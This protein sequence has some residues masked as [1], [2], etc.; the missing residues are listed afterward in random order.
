MH[1]LGPA[2]VLPSMLV[3][4]WLLPSPCILSALWQR[5]CI[6]HCNR[7]CPNGKKKDNIQNKVIKQQKIDFMIKD[8]LEKNIL[9]VFPNKELP[10]DLTSDAEKLSIAFIS[11][12]LGI[13]IFKNTLYIV[14]KNGINIY[15]KDLYKIHI[16]QKIYKTYLSI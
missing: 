15:F 10:T 7:H 11:S 2:F 3:L 14:I 5:Y 16:F 12:N 4:L 6:Y 1:H 9:F 13:K 8:L